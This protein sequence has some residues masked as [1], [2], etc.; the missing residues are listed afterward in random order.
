MDL[1]Q[2]FMLFIYLHSDFTKFNDGIGLECLISGWGKRLFD[3]VI[4]IENCSLDNCE[5]PYQLGFI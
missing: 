5:N 2:L 1:F 3:I 4:F